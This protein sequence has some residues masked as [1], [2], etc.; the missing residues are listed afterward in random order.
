MRFK[1]C[2]FQIDVDVEENPFLA[3]DM[4]FVYAYYDRVSYYMRIE[5]HYHNS[6]ICL[7][8]TIFP[9]KYVGVFFYR[10]HLTLSCPNWKSFA[11]RSTVCSESS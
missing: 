3:R 11:T 1:L 9:Y 8:F 7:V 10:T 4:H 5:F 2:R 6:Q